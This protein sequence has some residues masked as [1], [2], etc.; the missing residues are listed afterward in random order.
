MIFF[1]AIV[2]RRL[3]GVDPT[4]AGFDQA[5]MTITFEDLSQALDRVPQVRQG[6]VMGEWGGKR[7]V[8]AI[9]DSL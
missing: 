2:H 1:C 3:R 9:F 4:S 8:F 7:S 6:V 5:L